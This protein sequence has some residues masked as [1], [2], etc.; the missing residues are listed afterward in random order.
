MATTDYIRRAICHEA[1]H[2]AVALDLGFQVEMVEVHEGRPKC[3][4]RLD[5]PEKTVEERF[6]VLTG[7]IAGE[8]FEYGNHDR[9]ACQSD[10]EKILERRGGGIEGYL[11]NALRIIQANQACFRKLRRELTRRWVEEEGGSAFDPGPNCFE[12][13]S[14][15]EIERIWRT[16]G[17]RA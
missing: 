9:E 10:Q 17:D 6:T 4:I 3:V 5:S 15:E 14:R 2:A 12:L 11:P 1:G 13:M 7:G 16:P 8:Q